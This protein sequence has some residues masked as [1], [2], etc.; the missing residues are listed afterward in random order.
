MDSLKLTL[1]SQ[2]VDDTKNPQL[3]FE[4]C[5]NE[6]GHHA[7]RKKKYI[8]RNNKPFMAKALSKS[9]MERTRFINTFANKLAY[10]K[11]RK[12]CVSRLRKVKRE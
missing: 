9:I 7:P 5:W 10:T 3:V 12:C 11:Q 1:N 4:L 8:H 6:P 2:D